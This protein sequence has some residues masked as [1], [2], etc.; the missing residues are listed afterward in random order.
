MLAAL[1][2][3][4]SVLT[5]HG[6]LSAATAP[7]LAADVAEVVSRSPPLFDGADARERTARLLLVWSSR[8]SGG[9]TGAIGDCAPGPRTVA[10]CRSYGTMQLQRPWL[11]AMDLEPADVLEDRRRALAAGLVVLRH[12]TDRCGSLRAGLRAYASGTCAGTPRARALVE[13]RCKES[14][15]C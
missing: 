6:A 2:S 10:T 4:A 9:Q 11:A 15:V 12:L 5:A 1:L 7:E 3:L 13:A 14:G 8:E